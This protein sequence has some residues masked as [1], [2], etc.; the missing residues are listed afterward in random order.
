M[1]IKELINEEEEQFL[2]TLKRGRRFLDRVIKDLK[3]SGSNST[4]LSGEVAWGLYET[5]GFP[6]DLTQIL[7]EEHHLKVLCSVTILFE[8]RY[9]NLYLVDEFKAY[10][11]YCSKNLVN[12]CSF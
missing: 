3:V 11:E 9:T 7:A 10:L 5:Y 1:A 4:T 12:S 2:V 8:A 6:L